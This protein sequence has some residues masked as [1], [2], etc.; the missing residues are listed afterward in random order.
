MTG[1]LLK[2]V[3]ITVFVALAAVSCVG[4]SEQHVTFK[5]E[6]AVLV[7][8]GKDIFNVT[9]EPDANESILIT[10]SLSDQGIQRLTGLLSNKSNR[11][12]SLVIGERTIIRDMPIED[13]SLLHRIQL[14]AANQSVADTLLDS[15]SQARKQ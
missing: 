6:D 1:K 2:R 5:S 11:K 3:I 12:L 15:I 9:T 14:R 10:L 13:V 4:T 7:F 8:G